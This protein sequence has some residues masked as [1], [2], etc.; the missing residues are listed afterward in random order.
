MA[1][2]PRTVR[3]DD[4]LIER[5]QAYARQGLVPVTFTDQVNAGLRFL[6]DHAEEQR[7]A[8]AARLVGADRERAERTYRQ[9]R[10]RPQ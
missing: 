8:G 10:G 7:T 1:K 6:L 9:L 4:D 5:L 2:A 3:V